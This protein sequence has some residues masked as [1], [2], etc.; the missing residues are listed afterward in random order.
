MTAFA[1]FASKASANA[2]NSCT[3]FG[4][5]TTS[6]SVL[7]RYFSVQ[8]VADA[9]VALL[10]VGVVSLVPLFSSICSSLLSLVVILSASLALPSQASILVSYRQNT[11]CIFRVL[12]LWSAILFFSC[13]CVRRR[14]R[15][16][17][18]AVLKIG[19]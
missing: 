17:K 14:V 11:L 1:F 16:T 10:R 8:A 12:S 15:G 18:R 6:R 9:K 19:W 7:G 5:P 3:A 4:F 2:R 13:L